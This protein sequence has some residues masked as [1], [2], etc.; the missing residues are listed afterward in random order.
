MAMCTGCDPVKLPFRYLGLIM[1]ENMTKVKAWKCVV[2]KIDVDDL[3]E[4]NLRWQMAMLT[5]RARRFLQKI[6]RNL[7][8]NGTASMGFDMTKVECYNCHRKGHFARECRS[9]KDLRRPGTAEPQ[10]RTVPV[11]TSTSNAFVSQCD[12]TGSYDWS[13]QA[14]D[15]PVYFALM[16]F[17]SNSS[18]S[19]SNDEVSSCLKACS[20]AY[21]QLQSQYD[22]LTDDFRK[23]QF[24]VISYQTG[25][26]SVEA[27]LLVYKQNKS[28]FEENI[29]MLNIEV[30]LRDTALVTLK[31]KLEASEKERDDLKLKLEKFLPKLCLIVKTIIL[32]KVIM[33]IGHL[34]ISM[35]DLVF[36][37][38]PSDATEH[39]AFNVQPIETTFQDA[40]S[41]SA[42]HKSNSSGKRRN[43]KTCFVCKSVDHL[44][45]DCDFYATKMAKPTQRNYANR[46]Y[47]KQYAPKPL[48][49]SI[50]TTV[51]PQS[52]SVLTTADRTL[53]TALPNLPMTRPRH[54]YRV[55]TKSKPPIR[56]HLPPSPSSK[57]RNSPPRVTAAKTP[58][59]SA[60]KG[61][62]E[63]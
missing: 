33:T 25:L 31:Q 15:E 10:R 51:L 55:V 47:Y 21:S 53:S 38:A 4:M 28:V 27:R 61:K 58:V 14:E 39:L 36:H 40:P 5:M 37:T 63:T 45:K 24:D 18:S 50:T 20:K 62:T 32:L 8:A 59:V 2:G 41:V 43:R 3:E 49:H 7:G 26:E 30:Q 16:A 23:S 60:A 29:K 9:P 56:R 48:Q 35:I 34:V 42:S 57:H 17:S 54:A 22:K 52:Q 6:G 13:Y 1:G 11:E 12:G 44:I 19:S 46:G